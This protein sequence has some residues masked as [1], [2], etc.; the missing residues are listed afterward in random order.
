[1]KFEPCSDMRVLEGIC[2]KCGS[3]RVRQ[4]AAYLRA[5]QW[6]AQG[7]G[8]FIAETIGD[9]AFYA[10]TFCKSHF[11]LVDCAVEQEKHGQGIGTILVSRMKEKCQ[12]RNIRMIRLRTAIDETAVDFWQKQGAK[13]VG[14]KGDDYVMEIHL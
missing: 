5:A 2:R 12:E 6:Q 8:T 4:S 11:N 10:G 13:I 1:M 9:F 7:K 14:L 3:K